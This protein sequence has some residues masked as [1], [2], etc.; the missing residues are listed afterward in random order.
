MDF[1]GLQAADFDFFKK[2]EKMLK[3]EYEKGRNDV[4]LHFRSLCY[5]MQKIHHKKTGGVLTLE[6]DFQNFNK[7]SNNIYV[8]HIVE[9]TKFRVFILINCDHLKIENEVLSENAVDAQYVLD[10]IK[11]KK[12]I[13]WE[14]A[15][16]NKFAMI[17]AEILGKDKKNNYMKLS[18][19]D[20]NAKNYDSFISFIENNISKGKTAFKL[21]IGYVYPKS[22][23]LKQG[24]NIAVTSYDSMNNLL[25]NLKKLVKN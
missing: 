13:V 22:E 1:N 20:I 9:D 6:K 5:E 23:C 18:S 2:K 25:D 12:S 8:E 10:I 17:Y 21:G 4:K 7:R 24:K 19:L 3:D 16:S 11:N 14:L 15:M